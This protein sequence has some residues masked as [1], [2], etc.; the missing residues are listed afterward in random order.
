M[1][2]QKSMT[3]YLNGSLQGPNLKRAKTILLPLESILNTLG[4]HNLILRVSIEA[5]SLSRTM[6][7]LLAVDDYT[8]SG[9]RGEGLKMTDSGAREV[10]KSLNRL[11]TASL[12]HSALPCNI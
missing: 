2:R 6:H 12:K 1:K 9:S 3:A 11:M 5:V 8:K 4:T 7:L 10:E